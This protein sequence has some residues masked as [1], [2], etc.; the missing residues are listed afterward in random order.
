MR[1]PWAKPDLKPPELPPERYPPFIETAEERLRWEA[2][3]AIADEIFAG[4]T[5][6]AWMAARSIYRGDIPTGP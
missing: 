6:G 2:A 1:L 5:A 3:V 4:D